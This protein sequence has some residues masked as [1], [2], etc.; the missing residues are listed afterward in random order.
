MLLASCPPVISRDYLIGLAGLGRLMETTDISVLG[1]ELEARVARDPADASAMLDIATLCFLTQNEANV[2][3]ALQYQARALELQ[4]VYRLPPPAHA[5]LRLLVVMAP[6]DNTSNTPVDCLVEN[7]G[8]DLA[9]LYVRPGQPLPSLPP[10]DVAFVAIGESPDNHP[11]LESLAAAAPFT[12]RPILNRP[13]R[14]I[15]T[16]RD[17]AAALLKEHPGVLMPPTVRAP[18]TTLQ[19]IGRKGASLREIKG[20]DRF[21]VIVRPVES[22]G[23]KQLDKVDGAEELTAYLARVPATE[24][25]VAPF[26]DYRAA[27]GQF[28]KLRVALVDG[29]PF[30]VHMG[31]SDHW[32]IHYVNAGMDKSAA[33]RREEEAFFATFDHEFA[34]AHGAALR[35]IHEALGLDYVTIDCAVAPDGSLLVFEVDNAAIVH[36]LDD[37]ALYPY[38]RPAMH[39]IFDAFRRMLRARATSA[40]GVPGSSHPR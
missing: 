8:V 13:D 21:P 2:P 17:R 33:K 1:P 5:D 26:I 28:R 7:S 30:P 23:G 25:F 20:V 37:P 9:W 35:G 3:F 27:D 10:H 18:R 4:Q 22:Q 11:L 32:M 12:T 15:R 6:G 16:L 14:I 19:A 36:D 38:K 31:I 40:A 39:R 34:S 24:F 29:H